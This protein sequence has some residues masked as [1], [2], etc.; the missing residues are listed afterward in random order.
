MTDRTCSEQS[1]DV[2]EEQAG[3]A[4]EAWSWILLEYAGEWKP[5]G[6]EQATLPEVTR[7]AIDAAVEAVPHTRV[8]LIRRAE[9]RVNDARVHLLLA[10]SERG[11]VQTWDIVLERYEDAASL[12]LTAWAF[13]GSHLDYA[14]IESPLYLVCVHGKR[15]RCCAQKGMPV[16]R[17]LAQLRP[18]STWQTTH[19]GGHRFAATLVY[20]PEGLCY[21]RVEEH[22]VDGMVAAHERGEIY[23]L[24]RY[25]GRSCDDALT[26]AAERWLRATLGERS[27]D[28]LAPVGGQTRGEDSEVV[29]E[30]S[31]GE[32]RS[33]A[34]KRRTVLPF[35]QSCGA[36]E[37]KAVSMF[38]PATRVET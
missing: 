1:C 11:R 27:I 35:Q 25:R 24:D 32:R 30:L 36:S 18:E 2:G 22:E 4:A 33:I 14:R 34:M 8:Q 20:L 17:R 15:D 12:D 16:Y 28:A 38:V 5:K 37:R 29:F 26:Q 10:R 13:G 9:P 23:S 6:Y 21:G 19:L 3:T 31:K 7:A